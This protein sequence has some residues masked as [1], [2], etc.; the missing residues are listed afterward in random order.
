[1]RKH[2]PVQPPPPRTHTQKYIILISTSI[3]IARTHVIRHTYFACLVE[4]A[5][6]FFI[7]CKATKCV[8][9]CCWP[10]NTWVLSSYHCAR[11]A[12]WL[13]YAECVLFITRAVR[14]QQV[15]GCLLHYWRHSDLQ[16]LLT[17]WIKMR[18]RTQAGCTHART[19]ARNHEKREIIFY[20]AFVLLCYCNTENER[21]N[22]CL[23]YRC[24]V[25]G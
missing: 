10:R 7:S 12:L 6:V 8:C 2:P 17:F 3:V 25:N 14:V 21:R 5:S 19:H 13:K 15:S 20:K 4:T 23:C 1:V 24:V 16:T 11:R 9:V 22:D 18:W